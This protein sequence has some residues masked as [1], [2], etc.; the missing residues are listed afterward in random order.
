MDTFCRI[1][2]ISLAITCCT[3][4]DEELDKKAEELKRTQ[5]DLKATRSKLEMEA[6]K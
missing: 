6:C 5:Q 4:G 3:L 2:I 1:I